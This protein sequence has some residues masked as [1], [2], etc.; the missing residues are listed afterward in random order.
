MLRQPLQYFC[1]MST[2]YWKISAIAA[3]TLMSASVSAQGAGVYQCNAEVMAAAQAVI[4]RR[5]NRPLDAAEKAVLKNTHNSYA[6]AAKRRVAGVYA[7]DEEI[8]ANSL[9][10]GI[11]GD[12]KKDC[13]AR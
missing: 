5:D 11:I 1:A 12:V 2:R 6:T 4:A 10:M 9:G 3:A 8:F 13:M 7:I